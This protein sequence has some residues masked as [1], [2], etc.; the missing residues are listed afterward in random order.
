MRL[1]LLAAASIEQ[2]SEQVGRLLLHGGNVL[3]FGRTPLRPRLL[4]RR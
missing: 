4:E 1:V 3:A 2:G